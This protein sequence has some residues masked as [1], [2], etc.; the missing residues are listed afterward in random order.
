MVFGYDYEHLPMDPAIEALELLARVHV[1]LIG[2]A[3]ATFGGL[4][5]P[6]HGRGRVFVHCSVIVGR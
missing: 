1:Y 5:H 2:R 6:L 3:V 4:V